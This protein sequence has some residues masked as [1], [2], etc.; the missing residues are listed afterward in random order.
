MNV[1]TAPSFAALM[2]AFRAQHTSEVQAAA[3]LLIATATLNGYCEAK[4][5]PCAPGIK[6]LAPAL[7]I[8]ADELAALVGAQRAAQARGE[9]IATVPPVPRRMRRLPI[10]AGQGA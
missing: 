2:G 6:R 8:T 7:G 3:V 4:S 5:L 10:I 1:T 9:S